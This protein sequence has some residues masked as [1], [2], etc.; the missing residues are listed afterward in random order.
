MIHSD[1]RLSG[2]AGCLQ[3]TAAMEVK[4]LLIIPQRHRVEDVRGFR[5]D[6]VM[7]LLDERQS[8][9]SSERRDEQCISQRDSSASGRTNHVIKEQQTERR[10]KGLKVLIQVDDN[11]KMKHGCDFILWLRVCC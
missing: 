11:Q 8:M 2:N 6:E 5:P 7:Q 4:I 9:K 3:L 10:Q 1:W